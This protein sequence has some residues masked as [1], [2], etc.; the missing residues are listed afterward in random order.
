MKM[1]FLPALLGFSL[2]FFNASSYANLQIKFVESA[3]KDWFAITNLTNCVLNNVQM[4][5]DLSNS[6]GK[7]IFDT[8]ASGAGVEVFQPFEVRSG[9]IA[10][11]S[12][13]QV[14]DGDRSLA[15]A[16]TSLKPGETASFTIDVDDTL[17]NSELGKI[18][19]SS[20]EITGGEVSVSIDGGQPI[21][22]ALNQRGELILEK[23]N[24]T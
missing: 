2:T 12:S 19:V 7:L 3:P 8:T 20:S 21:D 15:V 13:D 22:G 4:N 18:R 24:C 9:E 10:L 6:A 11:T 23:A 16:I 5:I 1:R 14:I 17:T